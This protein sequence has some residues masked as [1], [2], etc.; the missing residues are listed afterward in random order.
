[1]AGDLEML[2]A[3]FHDDMVPSLAG[4]ED[5]VCAEIRRRKRARSLLLGEAGRKTGIAAAA[6]LLGVAIAAT[7]PLPPPQSVSIPL[8][9][10]EVPPASILE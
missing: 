4:M 1:M 3:K 6:L 7:R 10:T 8:L 5:A 9:L 2:L